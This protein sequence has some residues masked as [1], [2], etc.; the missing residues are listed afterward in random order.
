MASNSD[1]LWNGVEAVFAFEVQP[2]LW[3]TWWFALTA[4]VG[5]AALLYGFYLQRV[6]DD[7]ELKISTHATRTATEKP[8]KCRASQA[9][10]Y[11][12]E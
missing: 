8:L 12:K 11:A 4:V 9:A 2:A 3:Q 1:G 5:V 10:P 6:V 7:S